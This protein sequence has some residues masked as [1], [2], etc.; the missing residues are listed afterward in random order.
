LMSEFSDSSAS[1]QPGELRPPVA[2]RCLPASRVDA[3]RKPS[4]RFMRLMP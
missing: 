1:S 2:A 4:S 3:H